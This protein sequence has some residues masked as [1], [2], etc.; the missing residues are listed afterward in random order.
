MSAQVNPASLAFWI[1]SRKGATLAVILVAL[2]S[3]FASNKYWSFTKWPVAEI[4][5]AF[6]HSRTRPH[7]IAFMRTIAVNIRSTSGIESFF[8]PVLY[9]LLIPLNE[10]SRFK[11]E[12]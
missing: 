8:C 12:V 11:T 2:S 4:R 6:A 3:I 1:A 9:W 7:K 10:L 5:H